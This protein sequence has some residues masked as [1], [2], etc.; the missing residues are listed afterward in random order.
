MQKLAE[1]AGIQLHAEAFS[2]PEALFVAYF[3]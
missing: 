1:Y 3:G 2:F